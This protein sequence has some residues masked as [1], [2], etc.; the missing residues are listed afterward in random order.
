MISAISRRPK[1][2]FG[3]ANSDGSK[4]SFGAKSEQTWNMVQMRG[5]LCHADGAPGIVGPNLLNNN[6]GSKWPLTRCHKKQQAKKR[7]P[8]IYDVAK[9][10][11]VGKIQVFSPWQKFGIFVECGSLI[12]MPPTALRPRATATGREREKQKQATS[13]AI[14]KIL[15]IP[16]PESVRRRRRRWNGDGGDQTRPVFCPL[17]VAPPLLPSSRHLTTGMD[18]RRSV[19]RSQE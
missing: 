1:P 9:L 14:Q 19:A 12:W 18:W 2:L 7:G 13:L 8:S 5:E 11:F 4:T 15:K 6:T 3:S 10:N 17:H 16:P